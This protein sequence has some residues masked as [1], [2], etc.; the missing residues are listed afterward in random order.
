MCKLLIVK[1][2]DFLTDVIE[3]WAKGFWLNAFQIKHV[4]LKLYKSLYNALLA[5]H[6]N[7]KK[8][9]TN[10]KQYEIEWIVWIKK[11]TIKGL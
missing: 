4:Q 11:F 2:S 1:L 5:M 8:H 6:C 7:D 10:F 3:F 9:R